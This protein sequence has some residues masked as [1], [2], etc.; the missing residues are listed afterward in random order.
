[1]CLFTLLHYPN[2]VLKILSRVRRY[3]L[4]LFRGRTG[5]WKLVICISKG[6]IYDLICHRRINVGRL[7]FLHLAGVA[8]PRE[9]GAD[10]LGME[11]ADGQAHRA[12]AHAGST[13]L[14]RPA[15]VAGN[16]PPSPL[17]LPV[18]ASAG[19]ATAGSADAALDWTGT[20]AGLFTGSGRTDNRIV[21]AEG[22]ANW[23]NPGW[24]V[25]Y[26]DAGFIGGRAGR[27]EVRGRQRAAQDRA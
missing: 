18:L 16:A 13:A 23:G 8:V 24:A 10:H 11:G 21:D 7:V 17:V 12:Q 6:G 15:G 19:P 9:A 25:D 2:Q 26:D 20:Y 14:T 5:K 22:F 1:M 3:I 27:K 4:I